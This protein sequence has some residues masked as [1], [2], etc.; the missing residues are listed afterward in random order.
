MQSR[1][2]RNIAVSCAILLIIGFILYYKVPKWASDKCYSVTSPNGYYKMESCSWDMIPDYGYFRVFD[3]QTGRLMGE[4]EFM[5]TSG[6]GEI[7]WPDKDAHRIRVGMDFVVNAEPEPDNAQLNT[8]PRDLPHKV[9][10][11][12]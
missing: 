7:F 4:S 1:T 12:P 5:W 11:N 2:I 10:P 8:I 9:V 3:N 6:N